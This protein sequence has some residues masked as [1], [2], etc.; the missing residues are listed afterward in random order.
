MSVRVLAPGLL[1]TLQDGGRTGFRHLGVGTS[2]ALDAHSHAIANLLVGNPATAPVLEITL[3]GPRLHF[4]RAARIALC[5]A[6]IDA[7]IGAQV[8]PGWR[9]I[10]VPSGS[11][12][13]LGACRRGARAYLAVAGGFAAPGILGSASTDLRAGFGGVRGRMLA[14]GDVLPVVRLSLPPADAVAIAAWWI[15]PAPDL[16]LGTTQVVRVLPGRDAVAG[17]RALFAEA[18]RVDAASDRQG[19]RLQ[20]NALSSADARERISEPVAPGTI[21]LPADGRPIVLLA[22]AQ[23]HG[24][25]PRI[26]HVIAADRP[27]LAQLRAGDGLRFEPCAPAEARRLSIEQRQRLARI[28]LAIASRG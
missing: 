27:R 20:G 24:G 15:D 19:L 22:D 2:G 14:V 6:E 26:G 16:D 9:R 3:A 12:L 10:E 4:D 21:Q 7:R 11:E 13:A 17:E 25:Y 18:W 28:A 23:T 5:G 1:T 8:L